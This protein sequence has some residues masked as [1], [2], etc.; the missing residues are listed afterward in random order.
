MKAKAV[1]RPTH[2]A[3]LPWIFHFLLQ[4]IPAG[5]SLYSIV[6][7]VRSSVGLWLVRALPCTLVFSSIDFY[8]YSHC[9]LQAMM[10]KAVQLLQSD[11]NLAAKGISVS[12]VD[13]GWCRYVIMLISQR[14]HHASYMCTSSM[15]RW[16]SAFLHHPWGCATD[17]S[18][19]ELRGA[20]CLNRRRFLVATTL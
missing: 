16:S 18:L 17:R 15:V 11:P 6:S 12:C 2:R 1:Q 14:A 10:V 5:S 13:P 19:A 9:F 3:T 20:R 7:L 8:I 4:A